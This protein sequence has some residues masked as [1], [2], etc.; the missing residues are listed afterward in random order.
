MTERRRLLRKDM[1]RRTPKFTNDN[2]QLQK[3]PP[4][5]RDFHI[6]RYYRY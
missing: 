1:V 3:P 2:L 5:K 4:R 6:I